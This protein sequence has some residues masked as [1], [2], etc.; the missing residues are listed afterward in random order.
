MQNRGVGGDFPSFDEW[1]DAALE[2]IKSGSIPRPPRDISCEERCQARLD[3][4]LEDARRLQRRA[5]RN[6]SAGRSVGSI[7]SNRRRFRRSGAASC[8]T[9]RARRAAPGQVPGRGVDP[10]GRQ[11]PGAP[12]LLHSVAQVTPRGS[13]VSA[14]RCTQPCRSRRPAVT[15]RPT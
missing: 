12:L 14:A 6:P 9:R 4:C 3:A 11:T 2:A 15:S 7:A 10:P 8:S 1:L 13:E 5:S